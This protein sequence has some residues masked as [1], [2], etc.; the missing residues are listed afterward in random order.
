MVKLNEKNF[1]CIHVGQQFKNFSDLCREVTGEKPPTGKKNQDAIKREMSRFIEFKRTCEIDPTETSKHKLTITAVYDQPRELIENR[2]RHGTYADDLRPLILS[3]QSFSGKTYEFY[4]E[5]GVFSRY[6]EK[7]VTEAKRKWCKEEG[8]LLRAINPWKEIIDD[9]SDAYTGEKVYVKKLLELMSQT[10]YRNLDSLESMGL[11]SW[12]KCYQILPNISVEI[13][14]S[15]CERPLTCKERHQLLE[16]RIKLFTALRSEPNVTLT[17][18]DVNTLNIFTNEWG[19]IEDR[20]FYMEVCFREGKP[21]PIRASD[22][23]E[24]A[25]KKVEQFM[26]QLTYKMVRKEKHYRPIDELPDRYEFFQDAQLHKHYNRLVKKWY[27][28]LIGC[29]RIWQEVEF[30]CTAEPKETYTS[31]FNEDLKLHAERLSIA[32]LQ[33]MDEHMGKIEF[34]GN[35]RDVENDM[36]VKFGRP[37]GICPDSLSRSQS[38]CALSS[39]LKE[40]YNIK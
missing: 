11:L 19:N 39:E 24:E 40:L 26:Q 22:T 29:E 36:K 10:L 4:N 8:I 12:R 15:T 16:K 1:R 34:Y 32:F 27:P 30:E 18:E 13:K 3:V 23:Q 28:W 37:A 7:K 2:G 17:I 21:F 33:Y 38:A 31:N 9:S 14:N 6:F 25:I 20:R 35:T 5:V